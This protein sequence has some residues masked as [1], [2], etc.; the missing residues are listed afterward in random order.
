MA[1]ALAD[2]RALIEQRSLSGRQDQFLGAMLKLDALSAPAE[3]ILVVVDFDYLC[4]RKLCQ[5]LLRARM[6]LDTLFDVD[7]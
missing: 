3:Y 4:G 5:N 2:G 1:E 7:V 6:I